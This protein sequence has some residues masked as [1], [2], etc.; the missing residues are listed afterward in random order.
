MIKHPAF[1]IIQVSD[2][3]IAIPLGDEAM[4][5]KGVVA[6]SEET[7]YLL[8]KMDTPRSKEDLVS[9]LMD[10]YDVDLSTAKED[11]DKIVPILLE[12]GLIIE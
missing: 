12:N 1:E 4:S 6:L 5:F 8:N 11:V 10:E 3:H 9:I 2:D 7:A